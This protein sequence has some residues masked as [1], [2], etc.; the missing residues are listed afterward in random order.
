MDWWHRALIGA[1][2]LALWLLVAP[3]LVIAD[4]ARFS[5][6]CY[7]LI[8]NGDFEGS[9]GWWLH[10]SP[11]TPTYAPAPDR[12]GMAMR[13]GITEAPNREAYSSI[14]QTVTIPADA[15]SAEL[16]WDFYPIAEGPTDDDKQQ[17]IILDSVSRDPIEILWNTRRDDRI[18]LTAAADMSMYRG[19]TIILYFNVYNDGQGAFDE[20]TALY[21]D[22]VQLEVCVGVTPTPTSLPTHTPTVTPTP[23]ATSTV[24]TPGVVITSILF[25]PPGPD[26]DG[27][28]VLIENQ[29]GS[30]VDMTGWTLRDEADN[31]F[32]FPTF[33]LSPGASVRVWTRSG[34]NTATDLYWGRALPVW[35]NTGDTAYLRDASNVLIDTYAYTPAG[36]PTPIRTPT[37][38]S[39]PTATITPVTPTPTPTRTLTPTPTSTPV[40]TAPPTPT[41]TPVWTASP[42]PTSA[43]PPSP[44]PSSYCNELLMNGGF[45]TDEA[46]QFYRTPLWP[47]YVGSPHPV[48]SGARSVMLGN[49]TLPDALSYSSV[50]QDVFIP[51][52]AQTARIEF[53][54]W[55]RADNPNDSDRQQFMLL[56]PVTYARI[57]DLWRPR[58]L[59]DERQWQREVIDLTPYRGQWVLLYF[60]VF[61]NG[62]GQ[63]TIMFLDDVSLLACWPPPTATPT[64]TSTPTPTPGSISMAAAAET[65]QAVSTLTPERL[66]APLARPPVTV[67]LILREPPPRETPTSTPQGQ[68]S[69]WDALRN[70]G[71][72][73]WAGIFFVVTLIGIIVFVVP[74]VWR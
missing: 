37:P 40:G 39:T 3:G 70:I 59:H 47:T 20:T 68:R 36:T 33:T 18:W 69:R 53:W 50:R 32:T 41:P 74:R 58:P 71:P 10:P 67:A 63:R 11:A 19:Q 38:T 73:A 24:V 35:N 45:E 54:Y 28:Y 9:G 34:S 65:P 14:E 15:L 21:L 66:V 43:P 25:D 62:N 7:D 6:G 23:S 56:D 1:S 44:T 31:T 27:E 22:N 51:P 72:T 8:V 17:L 42:T 26:V 4:E 30:P 57:A 46:W 12:S 60:N 49:L 52:D 61:N 13:L 48:R 55:A 29:G 2:L 16:R 64:P 5:P